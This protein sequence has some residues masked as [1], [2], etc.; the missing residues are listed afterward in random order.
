[1]QKAYFN[2]RTVRIWAVGLVAASVVLG[3]WAGLALTKYSA[4]FRFTVAIAVMAAGF[5]LSAIPLFL[6]GLKNFKAG[7]KRAYI[8]L[9]V[10]IGLFGFA[11]LQIPAVN[12]FGWW[13]WFNSGGTAGIYIFSVVPILLG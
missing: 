10:G 5:S 11:Q 1:M 12:I 6:M 13:G 2:I 7:L 9:C 8:I 4:D 3:V